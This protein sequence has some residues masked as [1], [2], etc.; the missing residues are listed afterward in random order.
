L[1]ALLVLVVTGSAAGSAVAAVDPGP[2]KPDPRVPLERLTYALKVTNLPVTA[3]RPPRA[4]T[5]TGPTRSD[6]DGDHIDDI[7]IGS[8]GAVVVDYSNLRSTDLIEPTVIDNSSLGLGDSV[9]TGDFNGDGFD[10]VVVGNPRDGGYRYGTQMRKEYTGGVWI[11]PGGSGGLRYHEARHFTQDTPGVPSAG[12]GGEAFGWELATGDLNGDGRDDLA[13]YTL[14]ERDAR[15]FWAG[16]VTILYGSLDG[17]TVT[18]ATQLHQAM[19]AV[20]GEARRANYFGSALA[21]GNVNGDRYADLV[22]GA[23]ND[24]DGVGWR[25]GHAGIGKIYVFKGSAAGVSLSGVQQ[26]TAWGAAVPA[27]VDWPN[28]IL[29]SLGG[30]VAIAD[31]NGDG[32]GEVVATAADSQVGDTLAGAMLLV[33]GTA[34]GVTL[35]GRQVFSENSP[36]VPGTS[37]WEQWFGEGG[38]L[39]GDVTGDGRPDA[40]ISSFRKHIG[41]T[42]DAGQLLLLPGTAN[43]IGTN[44]ARVYDQRTVGGL[45]GPGLDEYFGRYIGLFNLDG[46]GALDPLVATGHERSCGLTDGVV[47]V[48]GGGAGTITAYGTVSAATYR[49][50]FFSTNFGN[51]P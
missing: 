28:P 41:S 48:F 46:A 44:G 38:V 49:P 9:A 21:I 45:C 39:L 15:V 5:A 12:L 25:P 3:P 24:N 37:Q 26:V 51:V 6:I 14:D 17:L 34:A 7:V 19:A 43:G 23:P 16:A 33:R 47:T 29:Q 13:I 11:I 36:G 32:F 50:G 22:V 4:V 18:G 27:G 40:L 42:A 1:A 35:T 30:D 8:S 20:P 10:D 2:V 31:F